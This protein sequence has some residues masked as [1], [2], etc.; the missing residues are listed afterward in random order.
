MTVTRKKLLIVDK[1]VESSIQKG[2]SKAD[3]GRHQSYS[4]PFLAFG[5]FGLGQT[6]ICSPNIPEKALRKARSSPIVEISTW[7]VVRTVSK[8]R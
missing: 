6:Y 1:K 8:E 4:Y 7:D 3:L 5:L 2:E